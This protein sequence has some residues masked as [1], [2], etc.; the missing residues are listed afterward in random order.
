MH[1]TVQVRLPGRPIAALPH[2]YVML[3]VLSLANMFNFMDRVLFSVLLEPIKQDL[4]LN[5]S[6]MGLLGGIAFGISYGVASLYMGRLA[7]TRNRVTVLTSALAFWSAASALSGQAMSFAQMFAARGA[8]GIGVSACPPTAHS[9]IGDYFPPE[10]RSLALAIFTAIGT[11]GTIVGL[12]LGGVALEAFGWRGAFIAFGAAGVVFAPLTWLVLREPKRGTFEH[13]GEVALGWGESLRLLLSRPT[14]RSLLIAMPLV[15]SFGG[16]AT[17]V[18]TYLQR[19]LNISAADVGT[20]GGLSLGLGLVLGTLGG[21]LIVN[22]LRKRDPLWEFRWPAVATAVAVL[23]LVP[24]AFVQSE[25]LGYILLFL[26]F[27]AAGTSFG[28]AL[29]CMLVVAE[30]RLRGS[31]VA[32][33]VLATALVSYGVTPALIGFVSDFL[34]RLGFGEADGESLRYALLCS[35]I[36]P[37]LAVAFFLRASRT[38]R[39]DTVL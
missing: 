30:P 37:T 29:A 18:P 11:S 10:R 20:Y 23:L 39:K 12:V 5:D 6:Q 24:F 25:T 2:A 21:G 32:L 34:I 9:L 4:G 22:A 16:I 8:V 15:M 17:W 7:D 14:V 36:L 27:F 28:P 13:A 26:A 1:G 3:V 31:M 38:A 35:L 33:N 19:S